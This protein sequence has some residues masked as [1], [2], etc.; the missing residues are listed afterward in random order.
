MQISTAY[1]LEELRV[2]C[3]LLYSILCV[4]VYM[5]VISRKKK[6]AER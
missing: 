3:K 6:Y 2:N 5:D 4:L 1:F